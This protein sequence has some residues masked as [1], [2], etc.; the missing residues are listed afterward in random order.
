MFG[1]HVADC[2]AVSVLICLDI[3]RL[4]RGRA[5]LRRRLPGRRPGLGDRGAAARPSR[6]GAGDGAL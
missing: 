1:V 4:A 6:Q 2:W 3:F 5:L